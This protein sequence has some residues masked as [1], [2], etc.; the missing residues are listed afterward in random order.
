MDTA[1]AAAWV[2]HLDTSVHRA[3]MV[4]L[5]HTK[6]ALRHILACRKAA[7]QRI[8]AGQVAD[9]H[10]LVHYSHAH[11]CFVHRVVPNFHKHL[12]LVAAHSYYSSPEQ[13]L[14]LEQIQAVYLMVGC[15]RHDHLGYSNHSHLA[16]GEQMQ[17]YVDPSSRHM[18]LLQGVAENS[19]R[20][21]EDIE[22]LEAC[23]RYADY[24]S[25]LSAELVVWGEDPIEPE[26]VFEADGMCWSVMMVA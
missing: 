26:K 19:H 8:G 14:K 2:E 18:W 20:R 15:W 5:G 10:I 11:I 12:E 1:V 17:A 22:L 16:V 6:E 4:E 7:S 24:R 23:I 3:G 21:V 9:C 25:Q 13:V